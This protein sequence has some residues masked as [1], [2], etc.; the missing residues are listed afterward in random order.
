MSNVVNLDDKRR[1]RGPHMQGAALCLSCHV[2][3]QAVAETQSGA[4]WLQC[5]ACYLMR[6]RFVNHVEIDGA[7]HWTCKCGNDLFFA[8]P[9]CFYCPNCGAVQ[10]MGNS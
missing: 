10:N 6:G 5:P 8:T 9:T 3:W 7:A 2:K 4:K 1:E